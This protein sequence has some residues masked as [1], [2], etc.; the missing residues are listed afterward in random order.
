MRSLPLPC[1]QQVSCRDL[2]CHDNNQEQCIKL[3]L[4]LVLKTAS[5]VLIEGLLST[6]DPEVKRIN[7]VADFRF[8][9]QSSGHELC[10]LLQVHGGRAEVGGGC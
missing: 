4:E 3:L 6:T 5:R 1:L 10:G 2:V 9:A 7:C 8:M